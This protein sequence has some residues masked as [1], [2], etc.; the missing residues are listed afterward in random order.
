MMNPNP[1]YPVNASAMEDSGVIQ[2]SRRLY[3]DVW[4]SIPDVAQRVNMQIMG[5]MMEFHDDKIMATSPVPQK[6]A[7]FLLRTVDSQ[8]SIHGSRI[9][10]RL[11]RKDIAERVGT[12]VET[13]IR[14][15]SKWSQDGWIQIE[16]HHID[17]LN[18][19]ALEEMLSQN[20]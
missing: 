15:L 2:I 17:I 16:D 18:R 5:R 19:A 9:S 14:V 8:A 4:Q 1:K 6:I 11:T 10:L 12:T 7:R 20:E 3:I 13:A